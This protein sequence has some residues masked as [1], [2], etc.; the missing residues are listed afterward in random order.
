M[1]PAIADEVQQ[2][3]AA[4]EMARA[5]DRRRRY[6]IVVALG[7]WSVVAG[8][9]LNVAG[10]LLSSFHAKDWLFVQFRDSLLICA[11]AIIM[12]TCPV[13]DVDIDGELEARPIVGCGCVV[14]AGGVFVLVCVLL[15]LLFEKD[16][17]WVSA[18]C[19]FSCC[20]SYLKLFI[21]HIYITSLPKSV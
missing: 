9:L 11:G 7:G 1:T 8:I 19:S 12:S 2:R 17:S 3:Y 16:L 20:S 6:G 4:F 15:S 21:K 5:A 10:I 18:V 14:R 13:K